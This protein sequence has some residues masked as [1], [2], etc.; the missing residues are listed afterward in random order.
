VPQLEQVG[1]VEVSC[2]LY[3]STPTQA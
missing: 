2:H 1:E 3:D